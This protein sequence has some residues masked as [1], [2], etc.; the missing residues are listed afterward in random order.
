M[1]GS[2]FEMAWLRR[3]EPFLAAAAIMAAV[4]AG[5]LLMPQLMLL[6]SG[7]GPLAG[8]AV[9]IAFI[10]AFFAVLWLRARWQRR[11]QGD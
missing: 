3:Y 4:V 6:V 1:A 11:A 8:L 10:L 9:A 7:G 5:W 2:L